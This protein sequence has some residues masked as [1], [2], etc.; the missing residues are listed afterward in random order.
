MGSLVKLDLSNIN[1]FESKTILIFNLF[2]IL[3]AVNFFFF[4]FRF[5]KTVTDTRSDTDYFA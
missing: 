4:F 3:F 5:V 1:D 2:I